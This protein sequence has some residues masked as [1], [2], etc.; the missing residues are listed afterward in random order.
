MRRKKGSTLAEL[1]VVMAVV[2][3]VSTMV[4]T[5]TTLVNGWITVGTA[6]YH[7]SQSERLVSD[8]LRIFSSRYDSSE[9][10]FSCS[11]GGAALNAYNNESGELEGSLS[12]SSGI[13]N[14][15]AVDVNLDEQLDHIDGMHLSILKGQNDENSLISCRITYSLPIPSSKSVV[16]TGDSV[17]S[18]ALR[19]AG[20][21][22]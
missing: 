19:A 22:K 21:E 8:N 6:R 2:S 20:G 1:V 16:E 14:Y 3:I 4:V 12:F 13:L 11:E 9:Y 15:R 18:I 7:Y 17:L 10:T 5:F